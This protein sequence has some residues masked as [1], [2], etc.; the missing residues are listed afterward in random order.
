[1]KSVNSILNT[2]VVTFDT[3]SSVIKDSG[4]VLTQ[5]AS[6]LA[7]LAQAGNVASQKLLKE[8]E[9]DLRAWEIESQ[10]RCAEH[11][12]DAATK[13]AVTKKRIKEAMS[14]DPELASLLQ[15]SLEY[16]G[17]TENPATTK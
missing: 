1:M 10:E 15:E 2:V 17:I 13:L 14:N 7:N 5:T 6:G 12:L 9:R 8:Q 4:T 16:L 3:A 11:L